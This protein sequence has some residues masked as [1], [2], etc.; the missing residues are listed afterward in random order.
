M[1]VDVFRGILAFDILTT[2]C[3]TMQDGDFLEFGR[4]VTLEIGRIL[5]D[6][7]GLI[8]AA[9]RRPEKVFFFSINLEVGSGD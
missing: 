5:E 4:M 7:D 8:K 6:R 9:A 2:T 3:M 1:V